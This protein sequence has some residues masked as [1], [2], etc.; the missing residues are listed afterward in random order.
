MFSFFMYVLNKKEAVKI[1]EITLI[2]RCKDA[3]K[4]KMYKT[5]L[6]TF[7]ALYMPNTEKRVHAMM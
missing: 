5:R 6:C 7:P 1:D 3:K 2:S 4:K